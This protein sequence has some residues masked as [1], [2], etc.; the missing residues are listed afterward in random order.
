MLL[1]YYLLTVTSTTYAAIAINVIVSVATAKNPMIL[2][3]KLL[4]VLSKV[5]CILYDHALHKVNSYLSTLS[6]DNL[7]IQI[8]P[9]QDYTE[10]QTVL[11][12]V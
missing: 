2:M 6:V 3:I 4:I 11:F 12:V 1:A 9:V 7:V 8:P 5:Q 10:A